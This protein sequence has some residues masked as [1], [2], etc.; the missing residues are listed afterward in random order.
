MSRIKLT[1]RV[2]DRL[3]A[4]DPSGKQVLHWDADL[5]GFG[6]LCSGVTNTKTYVVQRTLPDGRTRRVT[7]AAANEM[8]LAKAREEAADALVELRK[9]RDPKVRSVTLQSALD[10]YIK[11]YKAS[12]SENTQ[13]NYKTMIERHLAKWLDKPLTFI[14]REAVEKRHAE[15][16]SEV[17]ASRPGRKG[18]TSAN[19]VMRTLKLLWNDARHQDKTLP[20]NPVLLKKLWFEEKRR[21]RIVEAAK[22]SD[23]H[24]AVIALPNP[25]ARD[26]I[27]FVLFTGLRRREAAML[28]WEHVDFDLKLIRIPAAN[29]KAKR[30]LDLPMTDFVRNLLV[31]RRSVGKEPSGFVFPSHGK[32][33]GYIAEPKF[34]L[35][36]VGKACGVTVSVH[37]LRR[38][39][40]TVAEETE[41]SPM[42]LKALVNHS[43]GKDVTEGYVQMR[44]E[45]LRAPAQKVADSLKQLC[46]I[47]PIDEE[48]VVA[49]A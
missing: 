2:I 21:E 48:N 22:L 32:K 8:T 35:D 39:F 14:T 42:A 10:T 26:Y 43:L 4:P 12:L 36:A 30:K 16:A 37:D 3:A 34:P 17:A 25:I 9:G 41:I 31:A 11:R 15:I 29:T 28:K 6:V 7:V 1:E 47:I 40:I 24:N 19:A 23:F 44:V 27:L 18:E 49:M 38:T 5:K 13:A 33:T 46:G 20:E 45:R